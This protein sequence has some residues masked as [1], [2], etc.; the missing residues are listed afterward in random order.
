MMEMMMMMMKMRNQGLT[1]AV[2]VVGPHS[3][4]RPAPSAASV[5][6]EVP[7]GV[8]PSYVFFFFFL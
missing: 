4:F 8:A 6:E 7:E 3:F 5:P 2:V 1:P